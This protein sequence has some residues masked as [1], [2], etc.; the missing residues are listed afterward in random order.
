MY[1]NVYLLVTSYQKRFNISISIGCAISIWMAAPVQRF[2]WI[3]RNNQRIGHKNPV[4]SE[5]WTFLSK[6][7]HHLVIVHCSRQ[8]VPCFRTKQKIYYTLNTNNIQSIRPR[9]PVLLRSFWNYFSLSRSTSL[10]H[11]NTLSDMPIFHLLSL[12]SVWSFFLWCASLKQS[13]K[14]KELQEIVFQ[15]MGKDKRKSLFVLCYYTC[16]L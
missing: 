13:Q 5:V 1:H 14:R 11:N 8:S 7:P 9:T 16:R 2:L 6:I 3:P 15:L 12:L 4:V 10:N